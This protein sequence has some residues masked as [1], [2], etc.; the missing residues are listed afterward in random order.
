M[1]AAWPHYPDHNLN[2]HWHKT[3]CL[4][5]LKLQGAIFANRTACTVGLE[6]SYSLN[7]Y[8]QLLQMAEISIVLCTYL[9]STQQ[10]HGK[11]VGKQ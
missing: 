7:S 11:M 10:G 4:T 9:P 5:S 6:S 1:E 3:S 8:S 2:L